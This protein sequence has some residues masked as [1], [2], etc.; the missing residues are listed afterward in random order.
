MSQACEPWVS[1]RATINILFEKEF[2]RLCFNFIRA[3]QRSSFRVVV[4]VH[5]CFDYCHR[6]TWSVAFYVRADPCQTA[7]FRW[8]PH[9]LCTGLTLTM[10]KYSLNIHQTFTKEIQDSLILAVATNVYKPFLLVPVVISQ[11]HRLF[12]S[13]YHWGKFEP[14]PQSGKG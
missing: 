1:M 8:I 6:V 11:Q 5:S 10:F 3:M 4:R 13:V 14:K 9:K 7:I 2:C 12:S